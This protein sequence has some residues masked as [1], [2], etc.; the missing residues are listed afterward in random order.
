MLVVTPIS[1]SAA[2]YFLGGTDRGRWEGGGCLAL[3]LEGPVEPVALRRVLAGRHPASGQDLRRRR[4]SYRRAGWDLVFAAP[5]SLSLLAAL[6]RR[7]DREAIVG[8][9]VAAVGD[10]LGW[11][12][13]H[14]CRGRRGGATMP[15]GMTVARYTHHSSDA[16]EPHLHSHALLANLAWLDPGGWSALASSPLWPSTRP[17]GGLYRLA[18]RARLVEAGLPL[19]WRPGRPPHPELLDVE[20]VP[21]AA[22]AA[23][24]RRRREVGG[25]LAE[26]DDPGLAGRAAR[27]AVRGAS[28]RRSQGPP[29]P[30]RS[31]WPALVAAAGLAPADAAR[32]CHAA[33]QQGA[34]ASAPGADLAAAVTDWLRRRATTFTGLDVVRAVTA[35]TAGPMLPAALDEWVGRFC[36]DPEPLRAGVRYTTAAA[37]ADLAELLVAA[38]AHPSLPPVGLDAASHAGGVH[39]GLGDGG[40]AGGLARSGPGVVVLRGRPGADALLEQA[41]TLAACAEAWE[42]AG[43]QV[44]LDAPGPSLRRWEA[45]TGLRAA[46]AGIPPAVL[47]VD[48]ADRRPTPELRALVAATSATGTALVL[49]EGG[50]LPARRHPASGVLE[51]LPGPE[52]LRGPVPVLGPPP[53]AGGRRRAPHRSPADAVAALVERWAAFPPDSRPAL[54]G[55]GPAEVRALN[56]AARARLVAA[57]AL[58]GPALVVAGRAYQA[59]DRVMALRRLGVAAGTHGTVTEIGAGG[60]SMTVAWPGSLAALD[61][62]DA[63]RVGH[64]YAASPTR[65]PPGGPGILLLGDS[66]AVP[67]LAGRVLGAERVRADRGRPH[68]VELAAGGLTA[69]GPGAEVSLAAGPGA[70]DARPPAARDAPGLGLR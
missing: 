8:A 54:V 42:A 53:P 23:A 32:L 48:R 47:V 24:S 25:T 68:P 44:A 35:V 6:A 63:R 7:A 27:R 46:S 21:A 55:M 66:R 36:A 38:R 22:V 33:R 70:G 45:L 37:D 67:A 1:P 34:D 20:G 60:A 3:G 12:E 15:A 29:L 11:L 13:R 56:V 57:G 69:D 41:A 28:R 51:R 9:H 65:V 10:A 58:A 4:P 50:T 30:D 2:A 39:P 52:H 18:L 43:H 16:G 14:G 5:K 64:G 26:W 59:G 19:R 62:H 17:L 49:V 61:R 40:H 31:P